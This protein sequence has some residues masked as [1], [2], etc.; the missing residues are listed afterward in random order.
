MYKNDTNR[1]A[2]EIEG[3]ICVATHDWRSGGTLAH[4]VTAIV[5]EATGSAVDDMRPLFEVI[6]LEG[7]SRAFD[8]AAPP[9]KNPVSA[10]VRFEY[11]GCDVSI[12]S[13][14]RITVSPPK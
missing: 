12:D 2:T 14:G 11:E 13:D 5:S 1:E 6:D 10:S 4:S 9:S 8:S 7:L 3:E